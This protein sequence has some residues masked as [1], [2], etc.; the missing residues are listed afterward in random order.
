MTALVDRNIYHVTQGSFAIGGEPECV[1]ST[2]LG[3]CVAVCLHDP[4]AQIG[5]MNHYLLSGEFRESGDVRYGI[6]AMELLVNALLRSGAQRNRLEAKVFG[7]AC[8]GHSF[9]GIGSKNSAFARSFLNNEGIPC[10]SESTGGAR[11]R[12]VHFTP[13][14]GSVR[15]R[16]VAPEEVPAEIPDTS[17]AR[18]TP[19]APSIQL[20]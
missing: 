5:G 2:I 19:E 1:L 12:R 7:G 13:Y 11:A 17:T 9:S 14:D 10:I 6:N 20:F 8:F 4:V 15:L 18:S 3:S 16:L